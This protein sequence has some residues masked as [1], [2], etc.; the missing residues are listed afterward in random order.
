MKTEAKPVQSVEE[1]ATVKPDAI[2]HK[3]K[4]FAQD[5]DEFEFEFL[6]WNGDDD[7]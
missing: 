4:N 1:K 3:P 6:N 7:K 2:P 5:D